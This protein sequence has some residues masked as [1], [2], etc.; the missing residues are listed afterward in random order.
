MELYSH[1]VSTGVSTLR[2]VVHKDDCIHFMVTWVRVQV[3]EKYKN[4]LLDI[5]MLIL[6]YFIQFNIYRFNLGHCHWEKSTY[7]PTFF[8]FQKAK[9]VKH[10]LHAQKKFLIGHL[11]FAWLNALYSCPWSL[12]KRVW[13]ILT[14][15][16]TISLLSKTHHVL[17][18]LCTHP[19]S[20]CVHVAYP[21]YLKS[22]VSH[23]N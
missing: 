13:S 6:W 15:E 23:C 9:I 14:F 2:I 17:L 11:T 7:W 8:F 3:S 4:C 18:L 20:W 22:N 5:C 1:Y 12:Q 21:A 19:V 16:Q 10:L